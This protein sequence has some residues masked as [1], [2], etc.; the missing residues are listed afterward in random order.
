M[1]LKDVTSTVTENTQFTAEQRDSAVVG[2]LQRY[3]GTKTV[4][5]KDMASAA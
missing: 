3:R 1:L 2:H 5:L 4:L